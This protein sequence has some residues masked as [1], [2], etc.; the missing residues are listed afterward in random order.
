MR[1]VSYSPMLAAALLPTACS[2]SRPTSSAEVST[3]LTR[4]GIEEGELLWLIDDRGAFLFGLPSDAAPPL[5][6][7]K[8]D[9]LVRW[10][11]KED[12]RTG[13]IGSEA[14]Q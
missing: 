11:E 13:Q 7:A 10:A 1:G 5:A 3:V 2:S 4:C 14:P 6:P 9:C 8:H 12:I